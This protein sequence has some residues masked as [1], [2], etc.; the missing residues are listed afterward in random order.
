MKN[1]KNIQFGKLAMIAAIAFMATS[2]QQDEVLDQYDPKPQ[3]EM[4]SFHIQRGWDFD[5]ISRST[6]TQYGEHISDNNLV[7]EDNSESMKMGVYQ[8]PIG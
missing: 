5:K 8:Q 1:I 3:G 2:C 4:I 7:S 6:G